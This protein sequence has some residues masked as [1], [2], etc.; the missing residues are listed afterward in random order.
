MN[1]EEKILDILSELLS[2]VDQIGKNQDILQKNQEQF[3]EGQ[4]RIEKKL[5]AVYNQTADL[6]EFKTET[7]SSFEKV[8]KKLDSIDNR[9]SNLEEDAKSIKEILGEHEFSIRSLKRKII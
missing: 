3:Q 8:N 4:L 5:D 2:K 9:V 1:N 7:K 6:T